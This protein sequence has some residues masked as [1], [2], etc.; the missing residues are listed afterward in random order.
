M[1]SRIGRRQPH[2]IACLLGFHGALNVPLLA[3][4]GAVS[5]AA[6]AYCNAVYMPSP[7]PN[8]QD[9]YVSRDLNAYQDGHVTGRA[10]GGSNNSPINFFPQHFRSNGNPGRRHVAELIAITVQEYCDPIFNPMGGSA[11][12]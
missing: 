4:P 12:T 9:S 10:A 11:F 8:V 6:T 3:N 7:S 5:A 1:D 2:L